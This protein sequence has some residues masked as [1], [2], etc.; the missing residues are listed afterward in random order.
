MI[1]RDRSAW[2]CSAPEDKLDGWESLLLLLLLLLP[3]L[4]VVNM[5]AVLVSLSL[6]SPESVLG[7]KE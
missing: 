5:E 4:L 7:L 2:S 1:E 3:L 6:E